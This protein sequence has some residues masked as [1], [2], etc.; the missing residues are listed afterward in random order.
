[1]IMMFIKNL[2]TD[3]LHQRYLAGRMSSAKCFLTLILVNDP[4][5]S[6]DE[7]F[8]TDPHHFDVRERF[9]VVRGKILPDRFNV[10]AMLLL[11]RRQLLRTLLHW[12][13]QCWPGRSDIGL[14]RLGYG[15]AKKQ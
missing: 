13:N 14:D 12:F 10:L 5:P 4:I 1:M 15:H 11:Y 7:T 6:K 2:L 9:F 8:P 3:W